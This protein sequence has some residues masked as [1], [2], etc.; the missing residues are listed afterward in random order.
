M[1]K[2]SRNDVVAVVDDDPGV[3]QALSDALGLYGLRCALYPTAEDLLAALHPRQPMVVTEDVPGF[4]VAHHLVG[5]VLDL[6]LPGISGLEVA[7]KLRRPFPDLPL[8]IVTALNPSQF[9][10]FGDW[11]SGVAYLR[12]PFDLDA[13]EAAF[14]LLVQPPVP[15]AQGAGEASHAN[16]TS[17]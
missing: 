4:P 14:P 5:A 3:L 15:D 2:P 10:S 9:A 7:R 6:N 17:P 11:P 1:K 12:K 8:A 13:L 16:R